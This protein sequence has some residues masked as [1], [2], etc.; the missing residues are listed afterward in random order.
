MA[1]DKIIQSY[2]KCILQCRSVVSPVTHQR[3]NSIELTSQQYYPSE[4]ENALLNGTSPNVVSTLS[5]DLHDKT[6]LTFF[7][8]TAM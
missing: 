2:S 1:E 5:D 7:S 3:P 8:N 4:S 6:K